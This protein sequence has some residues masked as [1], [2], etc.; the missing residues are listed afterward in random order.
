M[1]L[2]NL[3]HFKFLHTALIHPSAHCSYFLGQP[4]NLY[5]TMVALGYFNC[6]INRFIF[7]C[8]LACDADV[9]IHAHTMADL[10][11]PG[12]LKFLKIVQHLL[13]CNKLFTSIV[14]I[15]PANELEKRVADAFLIFDHHS[16]KTIDVR[17]VGTILRFLGELVNV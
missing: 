15:N 4:L 5:Q 6:F 17:E 9:L 8:E 11:Y 7:S 2:I 10:D 14:E 16:N 3:K 13:M 12:K 1:N